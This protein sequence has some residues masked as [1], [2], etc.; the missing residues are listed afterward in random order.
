MERR[1]TTVITVSLAILVMAMLALLVGCVPAPAAP[2][3]VPAPAPPAEVPAVEEVT[4]AE[5]EV[6]VEVKI[7]NPSLLVEPAVC[8]VVTI[9]SAQVYD[10]IHNTWHGPYETGGWGSGVVI[11]PDGYIVTAGHVLEFG[12][13]EVK[14]SLIDQYIFQYYDTTDWTGDDWT[15]VDANFKVEG[16]G[17]SKPDREVYVQFNQA[18]GGIDNI[19][20]WYR[21]EVID[22]S[23]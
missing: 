18:E 19:K 13:D 5:P 6:P 14:Y 10:P 23:P 22:V 1:A 17:G 12:E 8:V 7:E 3:E 16:Q 21:A 9:Y 20:K 2:A 11:N 15:W 4:P